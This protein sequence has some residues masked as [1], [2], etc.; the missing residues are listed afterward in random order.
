MKTRKFLQRALLVSC[1]VGLTFIANAIASSMAPS[2]AANFARSQHDIAHLEPGEFLIEGF[3]RDKTQ[4]V[5]ILRT[6]EGDVHVH[7]IP[8]HHGKTPIIEVNGTWG[9]GFCRQIGPELTL[10]G[11]LKRNGDIACHDPEAP[12]WGK[13]DWRWSYDGSPKSNWLASMDSPEIELR[14]NTV[15]INR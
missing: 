5:L 3:S 12:Q 7:L 10:D 14:G 1:L 4:R 2:E 9:G 13:Q 11:K 6:W 8:V 15:Y